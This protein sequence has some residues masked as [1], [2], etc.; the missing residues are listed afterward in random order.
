MKKRPLEDHKR[1]QKN[2]VTP[3]NDN[4]N[5]KP[6]SYE[7]ETV[8]QIIWLAIILEDLGDRIGSEFLNEVAKSVIIGPESKIEMH[9][10][11]FLSNYELLTP[12]EKSKTLENWT[13]KG[14]LTQLQKSL[15]QFTSLYPMSPIAFIGNGSNSKDLS[16][17]KSILNKLLDRL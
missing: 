1:I 4:F 6:V 8:P 7:K 10:M 5:L 9:T 14:I 16:Y 17:Y 2:F 3:F 13:N 15:S 12:N 11:L